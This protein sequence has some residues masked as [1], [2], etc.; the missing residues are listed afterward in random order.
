MSAQQCNVDCSN[1][2]QPS[3]AQV[4]A[5]V[6]MGVGCLGAGC[7]VRGSPAGAVYTGSNNN[8]T[9]NIFYDNE[10]KQI[11]HIIILTAVWG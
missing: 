6:G 7:W 5:W 4:C 11:N 3:E 1:L 2:S 9:N 8:H 10:K